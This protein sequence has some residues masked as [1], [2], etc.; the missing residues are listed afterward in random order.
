MQIS[1]KADADICVTPPTYLPS[2]RHPSVPPLIRVI[3]DIRVLKP[4]GAANSAL[5][6]LHLALEKDSSILDFKTKTFVSFE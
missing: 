2:K 1:A 4:A 3:R 5:C 6:L